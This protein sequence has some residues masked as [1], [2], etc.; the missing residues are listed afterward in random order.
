[1]VGCEDCVH[2]ENG[3]PCRV[4]LTC[5]TLIDLELQR[6]RLLR[7]EASTGINEYYDNY[8]RSNIECPDMVCNGG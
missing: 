5:P 2:S 1:M 8:F 3:K 6:L 7:K 4:W